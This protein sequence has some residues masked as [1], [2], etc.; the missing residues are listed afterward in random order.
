M[1][2]EYVHRKAI[3]L[4]G[5]IVF[6][7]PSLVHYDGCC[8]QSTQ[9]KNSARYI[10]IIVDVVLLDKHFHLQRVTMCGWDVCEYHHRRR[11]YHCECNVVWIKMQN[12]HTNLYC[13]FFLRSDGYIYSHLIQIQFCTCGFVRAAFIFFFSN[14][15]KCNIFSD[16]AINSHVAGFVCMAMLLRNI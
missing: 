1:Y 15:F 2:Y 11:P 4:V 13:T 5:W 10:I 8:R 7:S 16:I 3:L 14:S 12:T 6:S 9:K